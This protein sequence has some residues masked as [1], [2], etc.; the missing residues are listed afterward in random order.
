MVMCSYL[1]P[2]LAGTGAV[3]L[4]QDKWTDGYL[5]DLALII[6]GSSLKWWIEVAA[7][8]SNMGLFEAEMSS[9]SF[10]LLGM[11]ENGMLPMIFQQR[12]KYGTP[13]LGILC[14]AAGVIVLSCMSFQELL[15]F[16]NF[17]YCFGMFLEFAAFVSLRIHQPNLLRPFCIPLNT[18]GLCLLLL[19]PCVFLIVIICLASLK[20][21]V[22]GTFISMLGWVVYPGMEVAKQRRWFNFVS[23]SCESKHVELTHAHEENSLLLR[24]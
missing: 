10:Q 17:L 7:A 1:F 12:S 14:S 18:S 19:P 9:N 15:E 2:L 21:I 5:A 22:L 20:T 8:L 3:K 13:T 24:T 11:G 6:G 23:S 4:E 16:V